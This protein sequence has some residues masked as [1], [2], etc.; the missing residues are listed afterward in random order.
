[1]QCE[2]FQKDRTMQGLIIT[3]DVI[4]SIT[5]GKLIMISAVDFVVS[6]GLFLAFTPVPPLRCCNIYTHLIRTLASEWTV[7]SCKVLSIERVM[8]RRRRQETCC[9]Y[10][11]IL[12]YFSI[13]V[14]TH[15]IRGIISISPY[16]KIYTHGR[17][18][19]TCTSAQGC[20]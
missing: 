5:L 15:L 11:Y 16:K 14:I 4:R 13:G 17:V 6:V 18:F 20:L 8:M 3:A 19:K 7:A 10:I 2:Q 12:K 1:M 9:K